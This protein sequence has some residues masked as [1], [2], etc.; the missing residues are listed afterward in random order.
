MRPNIRLLVP[1]V[2]LFLAG[3]GAVRIGRILDEPNRYR[4][5][6]VRV[7][8]TVDLSFGA[9]AAGFYQVADGT[10]RIYV[11]SRNGAPRKGSRV[12]VRGKVFTGV[13][14]GERSFGTAIREEDHRVR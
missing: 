14:V 3:C 1:L 4:N 9:A 7:D 8:G 6:T 12:S 11:I 5:R 10:G 2:A 13:T